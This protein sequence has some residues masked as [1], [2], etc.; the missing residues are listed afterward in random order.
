MH[1]HEE[2]RVVKFIVTDSRTVAAKHREEGERGGPGGGYCFREQ[3]QFVRT[4]SSRDGQR[5][6]AAQPCECT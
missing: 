6:T 3:F 4:E 1:F 5:V 2:P